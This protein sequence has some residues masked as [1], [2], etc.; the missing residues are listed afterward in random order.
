M[1]P[2]QRGARDNIRP[3]PSPQML[4]SQCVLRL[5]SGNANINLLCIQRLVRQDRR[6][7]FPWQLD[8]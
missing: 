2:E 8:T 5:A 7:D 1:R 3:L 6:I 4:G